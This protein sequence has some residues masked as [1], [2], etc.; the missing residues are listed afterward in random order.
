MAKK[1]ILAVAGAGNKNGQGAE[2]KNPLKPLQNHSVDFSHR[3]RAAF[4]GIIAAPDIAHFCFHTGDVTR[5][6]I[7][8]N[9]SEIKHKRE[10]LIFQKKK[11]FFCLLHTELTTHEHGLQKWCQ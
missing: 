4:I 5:G 8:Y 3:H 7:L 2:C 11:N 1:V 9:F 6:T 10:I